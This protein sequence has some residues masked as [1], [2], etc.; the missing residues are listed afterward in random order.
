M[1]APYD[2]R[3]KDEKRLSD[4]EI[5]KKPIVTIHSFFVILVLMFLFTFALVVGVDF[6]GGWA[7]LQG[8]AQSYLCLSSVG[9]P[10]HLCYQ[11]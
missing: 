9:Q 7:R 2:N 3:V 11:S 8:N 6:L 1:Q 5:S 4:S 10:F